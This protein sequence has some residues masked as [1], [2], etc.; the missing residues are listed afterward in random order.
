M[1]EFLFNTAMNAETTLNKKK[2]RFVR[3]RSISLFTNSYYTLKK[4]T[5]I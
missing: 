2:A 4:K 5:S 3:H 1:G